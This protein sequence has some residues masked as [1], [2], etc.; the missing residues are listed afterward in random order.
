MDRTAGIPEIPALIPH[1][2][3]TAGNRDENHIRYWRRFTMGK[4]PEKYQGDRK[5]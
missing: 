4:T 2:K 5:R 3:R 1:P